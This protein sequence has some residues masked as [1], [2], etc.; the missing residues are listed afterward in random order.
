MASVSLGN[1]P[2]AENITIPQWA[3]PDP[4]VI[5]ATH[6][7]TPAWL[8]PLPHSSP[9]QESNGS[10]VVLKSRCMDP[11]LIIMYLLV[12][13]SELRKAEDAVTQYNMWS[14]DLA[15]LAMRTMINNLQ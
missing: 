7:P 2:A 5:H 9:Y 1:V 14:T 4:T 3:G 12:M 8:F 6:P 11:P 10:I 15:A 13:A